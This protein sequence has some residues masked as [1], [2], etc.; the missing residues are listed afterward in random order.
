MRYRSVS[1]AAVLALVAIQGC[2]SDKPTTRFSQQ[3]TNRVISLCSGGMA[4]S[5]IA[6]LEASYMKSANAKVEGS[7]GQEAR[8]IIFSDSTLTG[9][10]GAERVQ[11]ADKY[12]SCVKEM[13]AK[14]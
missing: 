3:D 6:K 10:S 12:Q 1:F 11:I 8:G 9:V 7:A 2:A 13:E 14:R 4:Q 5:L